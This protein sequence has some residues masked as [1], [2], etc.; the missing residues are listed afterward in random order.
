MPLSPMT[1]VLVLHNASQ[2]TKNEQIRSLSQI[3]AGDESQNP[4][5]CLAFTTHIMVRITLH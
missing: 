5:V 1:A 4:L 2:K 3:P